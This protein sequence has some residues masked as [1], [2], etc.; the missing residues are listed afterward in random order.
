MVEERSADET[1]HEERVAAVARIVGVSVE[2]AMAAGVHICAIPD[3]E[4]LSTDDLVA[5]FSYEAW[6]QQDVADRF[7]GRRL[8][9]SM[10]TA[11]QKKQL[12]DRRFFDVQV[13]RRRYRLHP[14][15]G[16]VER[17]ERSR[18]KRGWSRAVGY[19]FHEAEGDRLPPADR[20][21]AHLLLLANDEATFLELAHAQRA[22]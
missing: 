20:T 6:R 8:L 5:L 10:L 21:I 15:F 17:V 19:C 2:A 4:A 7:K 3:F 9:R 22:A 12:R 1:T 14:R 13:G 11:R 18:N 16:G